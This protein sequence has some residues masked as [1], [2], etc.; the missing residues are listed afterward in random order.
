MNTITSM[1]VRTLV[2]SVIL[3]A[4]ATGIA[5]VSSA[6]EVTTPPQLIVKFAQL[7]VST[8]KGASALYARIHSAA[9]NVCSRMYEGDDLAYR[10]NKDACLEKAIGDAVR[11]VDQPALSA[12]F[13]TKHGIPQPVVLAA[14][15]TR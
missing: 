2:A 11:N 6:E 5:T 10:L 1:P 4:L 14:V 9:V 7:D 15:K 12:V 13:A 8:S 3:S